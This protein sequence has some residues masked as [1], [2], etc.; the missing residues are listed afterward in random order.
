MQRATFKIWRTD[1]QGKGDFKDY[2]AEVGEGPLGAQ[3]AVV[4][5]I[6]WNERDQAVVQTRAAGW[7]ERLHVR[8]TLDRVRAGQPLVELQIPEWVAAQEEFLSLRRMRSTDVA[9]LIDAARTRM[10][11]L[12]MS[13]AHIAQVEQS[14]RAQPRVMVA[15]PISGADFRVRVQELY[16]EMRR[17]S[18]RGDWGTY[19]RAFDA[20]G[21]LLR[22]P[23]RR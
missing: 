15:A 20:L 1:D 22:Q 6:A 5:N 9:P 19:G 4:G 3:L 16:D 12:G 18:A 8:A 14:G 2:T 11:L 17:A 13:E 21:A 23:P 10:R 7:V